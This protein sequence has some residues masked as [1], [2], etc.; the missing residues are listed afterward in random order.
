MERGVGGLDDERGLVC[1]GR[2]GVD[3]EVDLGPLR[4][5][6]KGLGAGADW[7]S[8]WLSGSEDG[9]L[10]IVVGV[11]FVWFELDEVEVSDF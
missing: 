9:M 8:C 10:T 3:L 11:R 5:R 1:G 6:E 7:V 2:E 4:V